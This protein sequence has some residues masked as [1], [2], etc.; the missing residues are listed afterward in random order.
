MERRGREERNRWGVDDTWCLSFQSGESI[1]FAV[2]E[3]RH[4]L[5]VRVGHG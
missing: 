4:L 5:F 3:E 1:T 2:L